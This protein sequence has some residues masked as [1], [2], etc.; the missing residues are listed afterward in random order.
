MLYGSQP[1]VEIQVEAATAAWD[2]DLAVNAPLRSLDE[3]AVPAG[4]DVF[5]DTV[6]DFAPSVARWRLYGMA[7]LSAGGAYDRSQRRVIARQI[8]D[9]LRPT[10]IGA[11]WYALREPPTREQAT[12]R[13][14]A[15][16][17]RWDELATL[18]YHHRELHAQRLE[19]L[20]QRS[21]GRFLE[22]WAPEGELRDRLRLASTRAIG[23][24]KQDALDQLVGLL[25]RIATT[26]R[27]L[28]APGRFSDRAWLR[29][30]LERLPPELL[31]A[32]LAGDRPERVLFA[33]EK[34]TS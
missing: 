11:L 12:A 28:A 9:A 7:L 13:I 26:N 25:G 14:A 16:L 20:V 17:S 6:G 32:A 30:Q 4:T 21:F 19:E 8:E 5:T 34:I 29:E 2:Q 15:L 18:R 31:E 27:R 24:S 3:L 22:L 33:I 10:S 1:Q 23:T